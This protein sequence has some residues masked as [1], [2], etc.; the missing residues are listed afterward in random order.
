MSPRGGRRPGHGAGGQRAGRDRARRS[1]PC[2]SRS[3][4]S[5]GSPARCTSSSP[6]RSWS[7]VVISGIVALT[8]TPALCAVLLKPDQGSRAT[9]CSAGSTAAS[10][11][12]PSGYVAFGGRVIARPS[13][14]LACFAVMLVLIAVLVR[15]VPSGF[16]PTEDKGYFGLVLQ[17]PDGASLQRTVEVTRRIEEFLLK[18]PAVA[19][20]VNFSGL[21][22]VLGTNQTNSASM[23]VLLKPWD[24]RTGEAGAAR[25]RAAGDQRLPLLAPRRRGVRLQPARDPRTGHDRGPRGQPPG[26]QRQRHPEVRRAGERVHPAGQHPAGAAGRPIAHAGQRAPDL[27]PTWT[28]RRSR[29]SGCR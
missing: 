7:S 12:P 11:G 29:R 15:R 8:L 24:E 23:F 16:I 1:A 3:R 20:V 10:G 14:W 19:Y 2:S 17:L 5:A 9:A 25:R 26:P 21:S 22:F 13:R 4:S 28:G 18:Q 27:R 6:S